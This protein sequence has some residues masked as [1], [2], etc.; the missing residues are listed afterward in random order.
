MGIEAPNP[1]KG[2]VLKSRYLGAIRWSRRGSCGESGCT[3]SECCCSF[4]QKPIGVPESDPR[5]ETHPEYCEECDLCRDMIPIQLF[6]GEGKQMEQA[7]FHKACFLTVA[8]LP[9]RAG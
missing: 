8:W 5:W 3:D 9:A 7:S 6:R 4:C 2:F 1:V